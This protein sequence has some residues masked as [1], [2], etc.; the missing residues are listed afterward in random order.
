MRDASLHRPHEGFGEIQ[1]E[2]QERRGEEDAKR[3]E[4]G[5]AGEVYYAKGQKG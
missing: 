3:Y 1:G 2:G 5:R 4:I